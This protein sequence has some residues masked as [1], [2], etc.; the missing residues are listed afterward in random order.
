MLGH[1]LPQGTID[2]LEIYDVEKSHRWYFDISFLLSNW[3]CI[4]GDGCVGIHAV[5]S[6]TYVR[7]AGCCTLGCWFTDPEDLAHTREMVDQLTDEDWDVELRKVADKRGWLRTLGRDT[8]DKKTG[9]VEAVN[10]KTRVYEGACIF[11]N[12]M[13]GSVGSTGKIG[14]AFH[15]LA[16][17]LGVSHVETKPEVCWQLPLRV[18][19]DDD[20]T[21]VLRWDRHAWND[22]AGDAG[23]Q[24]WLNWWCVDS[25]ESYVGTQPVYK[26]M[27]AELRRVCGDKVY[28]MLCD[29]LERRKDN[30]VTPMP[31]TLINDGKSLLPLV[32]VNKKPI[33]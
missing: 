7:D 9:E 28:G 20:Q 25:P 10:A 17:R 12:R 11:N 14:C 23:E 32:M 19:A 2:M 4:F 18:E 8:L 24:D 30:Y 3:S 22:S 26:Y 33:R 5:D 31:G 1:M 21:S 16:N 27:E 29:E 15:A 6:P 13:N